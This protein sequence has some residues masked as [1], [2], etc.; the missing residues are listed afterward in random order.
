MAYSIDRGSEEGAILVFHTTA[1]KA[2]TMAWNQ[3]P[4]SDYD[5]LD[6]GIKWLKD[7]ANIL[8]LANQEL[9][10][11]NTPHVIDDPIGCEQ[12]YTWGAGITNDHLCEECDEFP[13]F[14]LIQLFGGTND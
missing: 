13:G 7:T 11:S 4:D 1:K 10:N 5:W 3:W 12:C 6:V 9:L 14:E 8:P 2:K